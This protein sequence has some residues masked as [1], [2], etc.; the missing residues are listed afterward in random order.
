MELNFVAL[1]FQAFQHIYITAYKRIALLLAFLAI[2]SF[3]QL[4]WR[5]TNMEA[6]YRVVPY[7]QHC[8]TYTNNAVHNHWKCY[9]HK[10]Y[11]TAICGT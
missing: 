6:S 11:T 9:N 7:L 10:L 1:N 2:A 4:L 5:E 8:I 3:P